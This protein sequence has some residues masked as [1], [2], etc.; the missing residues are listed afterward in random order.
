MSDSRQPLPGTDVDAVV[1]AVI[2]DS[3]RPAE[4]A[5]AGKPFRGWLALLVL[6]VVVALLVAALA[7]GGQLK[8][9]LARF[10]TVSVEP[11]STSQPAVHAAVVA[12]ALSSP[13]AE[14]GHEVG[15]ETAAVTEVE[16]AASGHEPQAPQQSAA[17]TPAVEPVVESVVAHGSG[18]E[19]VARL[20][21]TIDALRSQL[22]VMQQA[23]Q[24]LMASMHGQQQMNLQVRLRWLTD[25]ASTLAQTQ[26]AWE[27]I[28][29]LPDLPAARRDE[30]Q[31]MQ[32]LA[33]K[34]FRS[35][36]QW[37][38]TLVKWA[39]AMNEPAYQ[40]VLPKPAHPWLAW[41]VGQFHLYQA[42]SGQARK[43]DV[44]RADLLDA[45][46]HL[47]LEIWPDKAAWQS[48]RAA[49]LLQVEAVYRMHDQPV[50]ELGLPDNLDAL[51]QDIARLHE[52]ALRWRSAGQGGV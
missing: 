34:S 18:S 24:Q 37:R 3:A 45:A 44:L 21:A 23:Q 30:A 10:T 25:P 1:D 14:E 35:V 26:Q 19:E 41:L 4:P 46:R 42:P 8:P 12:P 16:A 9:L 33:G 2:S 36:Q 11:L 47:S 20:L 40:D 32:E 49:L 17:V 51:Q 29:L 48:L 50:P 39:D 15:K 6:F 52:T 28:S 13:A 27:E 5:A 31:Q 38:E 22:A 7:A 43:L